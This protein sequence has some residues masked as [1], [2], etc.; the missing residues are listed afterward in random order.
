MTHIVEYFLDYSFLFPF[1]AIDLNLSPTITML[2]ELKGKTWK[3]YAPF[4][5]C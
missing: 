2:F 5:L 1:R 4:P 3:I